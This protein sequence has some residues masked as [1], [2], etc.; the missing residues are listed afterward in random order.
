LESDSFIVFVAL[1]G[2]KIVGGLTAYVL[3]QYY[4][5]R[6]VA[7]IYDLAVSNNYQRQGI[8]KMLVADI[9]DYCKS[10]GIEEVFVQADEIDKHALDF[11]HSTGGKAEKVV[12]FT[13]RLNS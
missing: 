9:N 12:H 4:S 7:Y 3:Q 1:S 5:L 6:P 13:Y 11:Y 8:G 10:S 2:E